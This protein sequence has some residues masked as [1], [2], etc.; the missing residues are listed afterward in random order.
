MK[1][2]IQKTF[3]IALAFLNIGAVFAP[4]LF[5][6][7]SGSVTI[8]VK[9]YDPPPSV[10]INAPSNPYINADSYFL[11]GNKTE[12][13]ASIT[14]E[15][16]P[17]TVNIGA[18]TYTSTTWECQ[19]SDLTEGAI[20][21]T[22]YCYDLAGQRSPTFSSSLIVD[23]TAPVEPALTVGVGVLTNQPTLD[24]EGTKEL[25]SS[26]WL[27]SQEAGVSEIVPIDRYQRWV[28]KFT[29]QEGENHLS[30]TSRD[31]ANNESPALI[32][33]VITLDTQPPA[34]PVLDDTISPTNNPKCLLS[35]A[36]EANSSI[37]LNNQE[38]IPLDSSTTWS[39][40]LKLSE[41]R[42][43][44]TIFSK[45]AAGN[46]SSQ[47][48]RTVVLQT[49]LPELPTIDPV[50]TPTDSSTQQL[51]GTKSS[52]VPTI[53]VE[54]PTASV[55]AVSYPNTTTWSC[56]ISNMTEGK[57]RIF[58]IAVDELGNQTEPVEAI[59]DYAL[60]TNLTGT[61]P[62]EIN[63]DIAVL[64]SQIFVIWQDAAGAN[65]YLKTSQDA[66]ATWQPATLSIG[67]GY[68]P[69]LALDN[70]AAIYA[71]LGG[72]NT[73]GTIPLGPGGGIYLKKS[74][75]KGVSF[76]MAIDIGIGYNPVVA[77]SDDGSKVY[78]VWYRRES[79]GS[80][81]VQCRAS[82]DGANTFSPPVQVSDTDSAEIDPASGLDLAT[83]GDGKYIYCA[84]ARRYGNF[85]KAAFS[86]ST[87]SGA[88]FDTDQNINPDPHNG[89]NPQLAA[90]GRNVY[91]IWQHD[92]YEHHH[93]WFRQSADNGQSFTNPIRIDDGGHDATN[94]K[95]PAITVD[96]KGI[97]YT[98]FV[99]A[100][101]NKDDIYMDSSLS[102]GR[103]FS[104]DIAIDSGAQGTLQQMPQIAV[105]ADGGLVSCV[106]QDNR[107]GNWDI[108]IRNFKTRTLIDWLKGQIGAFGFLD[109]FQD[110]GKFDAMAY[111]QAL[112]VIALTAAS[113]HQAAKKIL[114][115]LKTKQNSD[116]SWYSSYNPDT[117]ENTDAE[118]AKFV[119]AASWIIAAV[120]FYASAAK[121]VSYIDMAKSAA[122]WIYKF[123]D[124]DP[125]S[126][127]Y[128]SLTGG[129]LGSM[130]IDWRSTE[131]NLDA[132]SAFK[133]LQKSLNENNVSGARNYSSS[134]D[135]IQAYLMAK[136]WDGSRFF[137][138][139]DDDSRFLDAQALAV[140]S[141]GM[142]P[143]GIDIRPA[144]VWAVDN[145]TLQVDWD[146]RVKGVSGFDE[147]VYFGQLPNKLWIEG[148]EQMVSAYNT[149]GFTNKANWFH[150]QALR[151][152]Q[153]NLGIPYST[154][155]SRD[156]PRY[157]SV[158]SA[159][160]FYFNEH[161]PFI[162][163]LDPLSAEVSVLT[164]DDF[165]D[166]LPNENSLGFNTDD[167]AAC[168]TDEDTAGRH[169][170]A[171]DTD[172]AYWYSVLFGGLTVDK[173]ISPYKYISF[174][175]KSKDADEDFIVR[176]K[177]TQNRIDA[178][179]KDYARL[180][181]EWQYVNIPL[182]DFIARGFDSS[183][184]ESVAFV[185]SKSQSGEIWF[186]DLKFSGQRLVPFVNITT[187]QKIYS[188]I[189]AQFSSA[190]SMDYD[191]G[192]EAWEWDFKDGTISN[193]ANPV[194]TY[195]VPGQYT[196]SLKVKDNDGITASGQKDIMVYEAPLI[197]GDLTFISDKD[198]D[199]IY[200]DDII[201]IQSV[202]TA[203]EGQNLQHRF[204]IDGQVVQDYSADTTYTWDTRT[205]SLGRHFVEYDVKDE[206]GNTA[207]RQAY[208][209]AHRRPIAPPN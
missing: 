97:V 199:L 129:Y 180:S 197:S 44:I 112:A 206:Y 186:D 69:K 16:T 9:V 37:W 127:T 59:I 38:A 152:Q 6:G 132:Y 194:H 172:L 138:G 4:L 20:G 161:R 205:A 151:L 163:P 11:T 154:L 174:K 78:C 88:T 58:V 191:G 170:I 202:T 133:Y 179:I 25:H 155:G 159:C 75:D 134:A 45:D 15:V 149:A 110:D 42:N 111:D 196:I 98:N 107:A 143:A 102:G 203:V 47:V 148:T 68:L 95:T 137:T 128:G 145:F 49:T 39:Y 158:S 181:S 100:T 41:G 124:T 51:T 207:H 99:N 189:P 61:A 53:Y 114:A 94:Y 175:I 23:K 48:T 162:N 103:D 117:G 8:T 156:W 160:W 208:V 198:D 101:D 166:T 182:A 140:L 116:G 43:D 17:N 118:N 89:Y 92:A 80:F 77:V 60:L 86:A 21:L 106:W 52:D 54:C 57:N 113:E 33:S 165:N 200:I 22:V 1:K 178:A 85:W 190:G 108:Y 150:K 87:D 50:I 29:L 123:Q 204:K 32:L 91:I 2:A 130:A 126:P 74:T 157:N 82:S 193:E 84:F 63:P 119:G 209:Y 142:Q 184:A 177:D 27:N 109:S 64:D 13:A 121:D 188:R 187:P 24:L 79:G 144:L 67:D 105:N 62:D 153:A 5:A 7:A 183:H 173:D 164:V 185:F 81:T 72:G 28:S 135:L 26:V 83:T 35:G 30:L 70:S 96:S 141:L 169:H 31:Y 40:V 104:E 167:D 120:N 136:M 125:K 171:W 195:L 65:V 19:L 176:L 146:S 56:T 201:T 71:V 76:G 12:D 192:I 18:K 55:S 73:K 3:L 115:A 14:L 168:V 122:E 46:T 90:L 66:G 147:R 34:A 139:W 93:I 36:K 131:H 10:D